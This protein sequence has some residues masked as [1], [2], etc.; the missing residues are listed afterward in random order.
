MGR[1]ESKVGLEG[2]S[3]GIEPRF[4]IT[5]GSTCKGSCSGTCKSGCVASCASDCYGSM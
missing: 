2:N 4:C 5:C 3:G 1:Y